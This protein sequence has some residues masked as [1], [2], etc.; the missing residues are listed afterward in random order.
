RRWVLAMLARL[1]PP[2][3]PSPA[4]CGALR[5]APLPPRAERGAFDPPS[6]PRPP[7]GV[8]TGSVPIH[9]RALAAQ[10]RTG[11]ECSHVGIR[12]CPHVPMSTIGVIEFFFLQKDA[13]GV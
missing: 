1:G 4:P 11:S 6:A 9:R 12:P 10:H 2:A 5:V 7:E 13:A 8:G 3:P